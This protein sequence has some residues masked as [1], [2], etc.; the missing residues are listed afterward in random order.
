M[1]VNVEKFFKDYKNIYEAV[2]R[3]Q[4]T[5]NGPL[6]DGIGLKAQTLFEE[7]CSHI[8]TPQGMSISDTIQ[9]LK[10]LR[11]ACIALQTL[12]NHLIEIIGQELN[13]IHEREME[14]DVPAPVIETQE[15]VDQADKQVQSIEDSNLQVFKNNDRSLS[16]APNNNAA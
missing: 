4:H 7:V 5:L 16:L 9:F 12:S 6:L 15:L 11:S 3:V 8:S 13:A 1:N 10:V 2:M 14:I